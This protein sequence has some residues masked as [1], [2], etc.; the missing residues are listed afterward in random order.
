MSNNKKDWKRIVGIIL[1]ATLILSIGYSIFKIFTAP[2]EM[3][4]A[5]EYEHIRSDYILMLLQC[6]LG[7]IVMFLP[8]LLEKK[9]SIHI[10]NY[11][12]IMYFAF[13]FCAIVLGE[14]RNFYYIVPHWDTI[15]HAFSGG[16]LGA[17]GFTLVSVLNDSERT[18][19]RLSPFF[20][21][22]FA[23]SFAL[24]VGVIWEI[25]E[26]TCD[27][28]FDLNMQKYR[29]ADSTLLIGRAAISDTMKDFIV[30]TLSALVVTVI[31]FITLKRDSKR[32]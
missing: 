16:M 7:I 18:K 3:L 13:L 26:F 14:V 28:L 12:S 23:F 8:T 11:M 4:E 32:S 9:W 6:C 25:Y 21:A 31:G 27:L 24:A 1:I 29:L 17:L 30:N 22:L 15:L 10:P 19:V 2:S 5:E 20:V